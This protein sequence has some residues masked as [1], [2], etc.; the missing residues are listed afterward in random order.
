MATG[1]D[2]TALS[3]LAVTTTDA[4]AALEAN[5][6]GDRGLVLRVTPPY[7]GRQRARLHRPG[8][9]AADVYDAG[10]P[11][12]LDPADLFDDPPAY[13]TADETAATLR[14]EGSYSRDRHHD[15]HVDAV[16]RWR[17]SLRDV[18]ADRV[19][20]ETPAGPHDVRLAWLG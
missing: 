17:R 11:I 14:A 20:V 12:H 9:T 15:R 2:P 13:P 19:T 4:I 1:P 7:H 5:C 16:E 18:R 10:D 3:V 8:A 6:Q